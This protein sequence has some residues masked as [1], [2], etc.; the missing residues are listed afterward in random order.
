MIERKAMDLYE[1]SGLLRK[2][3]N[4]V[5]SFR[6]LTSTVEDIEDSYSVIAQYATIKSRLSSMGQPS[7]AVIP[8]QQ[9]IIERD[10]LLRNSL[11]Y[12]LEEM[13][14]ALQS[15]SP[16]TNLAYDSLN[17]FQKL[18]GL[19]HLAGLYSPS[20]KSL[21]DKLVK[22]SQ[23]HILKKDKEIVV[24]FWSDGENVHGL[25]PDWEYNSFS[26]V[27]KHKK[28]SKYLGLAIAA[29][30]STGLALGALG[31]YYFA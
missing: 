30:L 11:E 4:F 31:M 15:K 6:A 8:L 27:R 16:S 24:S 3:I 2:D 19:F 5:K 22:E 13:T 18:N 25:A 7:A 20:V 10:R 23:R 29:A 12:E 21:E 9:E 26:V 17:K 1:C 28:P 14:N